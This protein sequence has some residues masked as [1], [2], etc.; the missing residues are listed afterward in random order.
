MVIASLNKLN[1]KIGIYHCICRTGTKDRHSVVRQMREE[2]TIPWTTKE[3][4]WP[5]LALQSDLLLTV[6]RGFPSHVYFSS[7]YLHELQCLTSRLGKSRSFQ[8]LKMTRTSHGRQTQQWTK[9]QKSGKKTSILAV[10]I[11]RFSVASCVLLGN[12]INKNMGVY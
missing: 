5:T 7:L 4:K 1:P 2:P 6:G 9:T 10:A 11:S 8:I 3:G 12:M